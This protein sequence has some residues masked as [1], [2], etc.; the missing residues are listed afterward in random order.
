M[1]CIA[2]ESPLTML[3]ADSDT[4]YSV[5]ICKSC[6]LKQIDIE[7]AKGIE[8]YYNKDFWDRADYQE[9]T[10]TD[11]TDKKVQDLVLSWKSW[12]AYF[13]KYLSD[14]KTVLD[15]G[16]GTG[17]SLVMLE[18]EGKNVTGI[19]LDKRNVELINKK[20]KRGKCLFGFFEEINLDKKFEIIW[21][22]H[23]FE[24]VKNPNIFLKKCHDLLNDDGILCIVVP[25]GDSPSMLKQSVKNKFHLYH[26]SK[27]SLC[28]LGQK[29]GFNVISCDSVATM[30]RNVYRMHKLIRIC[31][32]TTISEKI[33][34][35]YPF[36]ITSR[37]NGYEI[38]IALKKI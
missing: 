25:D 34:P 3:Y 6:N 35:L 7:Q 28:V 36:Y 38:R 17:I 31:K 37:N 8:D 10:G 32:F 23:S 11:F 19:E 21:S 1:N 12:Y 22:S 15:I 30:R 20:L 9:F 14:R 2:C 18:K 16:S 5:Y 27:N 13:K 26:Y 4:I 29:H 33:S 24:H